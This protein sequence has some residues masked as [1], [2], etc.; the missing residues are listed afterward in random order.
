MCALPS[1]P[2][3]PPEIAIQ[4]V[5]I[6]PARHMRMTPWVGS[7]A[8][9]RLPTSCCSTTSKS[10]RSPRSGPMGSRFRRARVTSA[11]VPTIDW[12][13]WASKTMN[14]GRGSPP[15]ISPLPRRTR[16]R[17]HA[18]GPAAAV[19]LA[20]RLHHHGLAGRR[21]ARCSATRLA[22]SPNSRSSTAFPAR[23]SV[24]D[25]LARLRPA[26]R[27]IRRSAARSRTTS[28]ISGRRL[29]RRGDGDGGEPRA[30]RSAAA[31]CWSAAA[32]SLRRGALRDR[33]ADDRAPGRSARCRDAGALRARRRRSNGSTSRP[34]R[35]AGIRAFPSGFS[36][37]R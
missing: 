19:P 27:R 16:P 15:R 23:R 31:G 21:T 18:G 26:R 20:R 2:A 30:R 7:I 13:E 10:C 1:S 24:A 6:N 22:M 5:T 12:P 33:R 34:S 25:V 9:G 8:P 37:R 29:V 32:R 11:R 14:I 28:T 17:N 35:R 36:S 3:L 4:C